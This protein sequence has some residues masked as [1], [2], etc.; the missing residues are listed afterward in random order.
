VQKAGVH[1]SPQ[2]NH[3]L[4]DALRGAAFQSCPLSGGRR[5]GMPPGHCSL[6][7]GPQR[8]SR[9]QLSEGP[10]VHHVVEMGLEGL[11]DSACCRLCNR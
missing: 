1:W 8:P 7:A 11:P 9:L 6:R 5:S 10:A 4:G 3:E 2:A